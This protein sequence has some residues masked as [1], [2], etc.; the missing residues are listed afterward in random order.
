M[1]QLCTFNA[2]Y[3]ISAGWEFP[4]GKIE[5][6]ETPQKALKRPAMKSQS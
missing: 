2:K 6:G 5:E 3:S 1:V 4:G